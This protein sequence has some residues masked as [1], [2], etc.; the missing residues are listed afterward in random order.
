MPVKVLRVVDLSVPLDRDTPAYPG[1]PRFG[2]EPA[3]TL[4]VDGFNLLALTLGTQTGTHCDAPRH[5]DDRGAA[6]DEVPLEVFAGSGV[7]VDATHRGAREAVVLDDVAP[8]LD[9]VGPTTPVLVRTG[10]DRHLGTPAWFD[11][12]FLHVDACRAFVDR[13]VR[14][15]GFD[16]PSIDETPDVH[17]PGG[18][19]P[20][21]RLTSAAGVVVVE[22]L[23]GLDRIDFADPFVCAFPLRIVQ[24]DGAPMRAVALHLAVD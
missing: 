24:A 19:E 6:V 1:D 20:C 13:G 3:A 8:W 23:Q 18:G 5:F 7:V 9:E 4:A 21:H 17:H 14:L 12:P 11:H 16:T 2:A 22:Y 10:W 15:L